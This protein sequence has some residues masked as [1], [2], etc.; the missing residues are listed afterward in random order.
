MSQTL[1]VFS[2]DEVRKAK[3]LLATQVSTMMG[4]KLEEGDWST[5][6]CKSK[7]IPDG[8]WSNLHIDIDYKG[9]GVEHKLL[10]FAN[11]NGRTIKSVCGTTQM[12]P[13]ATRS[14][15]IDDLLRPANDVMA[16]VFEQYSELIATRTERVRTHFPSVEPDMRT[17]WLLW[18]SSLTEFLYF[19]E[20]MVPPN[21]EQYYA[22]WNETTARGTRKASKSLWVYDR[23]TNQ[24]RFSVTTNAGIKI[25]PYFDVPPP[26]DPN[27]YFFRVQSEP[28]DLDTIF[29]WVAS[30]TAK[31]LKAELG[32]L[33]RERVSLAVAKLVELGAH[34]IA[35][36]D[37]E[38][39]YAVPIPISI[40][41]HILLTRSWEGVSDEHY[42]QLLLK[43]FARNQ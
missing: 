13:S 31:A 28:V 43:S 37:P 27:L 23:D 15:R 34:N 17:G 2:I 9:L 7:D 14:I 36:S 39:D 20:R 19:E 24:K 25:Q 40:E 10:R 38:E 8:G 42:A 30:S 12:H 1:P 5:V 32:E 18:E 3:L 29:L 16:A 21:P 26:N 33:T 41:A 22:E 35:P 6:Y 11:L 4:R